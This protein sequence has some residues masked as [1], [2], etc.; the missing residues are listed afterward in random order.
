LASGLGREFFEIFERRILKRDADRLEI[1]AGGE[2]R[3]ILAGL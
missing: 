1:D 2:A 3:E